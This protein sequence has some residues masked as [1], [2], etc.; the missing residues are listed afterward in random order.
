MMGFSPTLPLIIPINS[1]EHKNN[2]P[3]AWKDEQK[4]VNFGG[5]FKKKFFF[6]FLKVIFQK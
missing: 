6:L 2:Y 4:Q 1:P 3:R 5:K